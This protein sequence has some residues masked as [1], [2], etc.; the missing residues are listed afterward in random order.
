MA[1][2]ADAEGGGRLIIQADAKGRAKPLAVMIGI[3]SEW[4]HVSTMAAVIA[5]LNDPRA[6]KELHVNSA[7]DDPAQA[8]AGIAAHFLKSSCDV[9]VLLEKGVAPTVPIIDLAMLGRDF[10]GCPRPTIAYTAPGEAQMQWNV[11]D[12]MGEISQR[13]APTS[14]QALEQVDGVGFGCL[15]LTKVALRNRIN[16]LASGAV[17]FCRACRKAGVT[18]WAHYGAPCRNNRAVDLLAVNAILVS[19]R[20]RKPAVAIAN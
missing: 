10:V 15:I 1:G 8:R 17:Q 5:A 19:E 18:I 13:P 2:R 9:L 4:C 7:I 16:D 6:G 14:G 11:F 3:N 12:D 20:S